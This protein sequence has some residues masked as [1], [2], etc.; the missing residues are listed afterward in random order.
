MNKLKAIMTNP[1]LLGAQGFVLGALLLWTGPQLIES[2]Q[3]AAAPAA[4]VQLVPAA[5]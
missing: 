4:E 1:F 3:A 2:A 5:S